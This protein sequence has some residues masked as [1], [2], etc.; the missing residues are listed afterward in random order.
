MV[1]IWFGSKGFVG[2]SL[3]VESSTQKQSSEWSAVRVGA[4]KLYRSTPNPHK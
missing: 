4:A 3:T 1:L 2:F